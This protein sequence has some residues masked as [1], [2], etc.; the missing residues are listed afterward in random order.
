VLIVLIAVALVA[1]WRVVVRLV[2]ALIAV[3]ILV[4]I[5]AGIIGLMR[6]MHGGA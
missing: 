2:I 4:T 6:F 3:G 5:G 1:F